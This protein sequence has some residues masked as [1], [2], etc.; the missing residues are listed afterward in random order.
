MQQWLVEVQKGCRAY[1]CLQGLRMMQIRQEY[2]KAH[3][4]TA[5]CLA[6]V[7]ADKLRKSNAQTRMHRLPEPFAALLWPVAQAL[8]LNTAVYTGALLL[9]LAPPPRQAT[10]KRVPCSTKVISAIFN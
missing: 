7:L 1:G 4:G 9:P 5:Q 8:L 3:G 2:N 10:Q 6:A